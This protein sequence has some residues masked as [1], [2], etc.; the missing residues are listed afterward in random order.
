MNPSCRQTSITS[1]IALSLCLVIIANLIA[2]VF[3]SPFRAKAAPFTQAMIRLDRMAAGE[4]DDI[5]VVVKPAT[6]AT[7]NDF[8]I[9]FH[10]DFSVDSTNTNITVSTTGLPAEVA[11][12]SLTAWPGIGS[13]A[14][15]VSGELVTFSSDD[16]TPGTLYGFFITGGITN[17]ATPGQ[18][19][20]TMRTRD[21]GPTEIDSTDVALRIISDDQIVITAIVP[22]TF[23]FVLSANADSFVDDL[24]PTAI[25]ATSGVTVTLSTNAY[26]GWVTW[27]RSQN[28]SLDSA[29][30]GESI[31]TQGTIDG[32][33]TT[34]TAG[35]NFYQLAVEATTDSGVGT[36]TVTIAPEY[37]CF[38]TASQGGT[39]SAIYEEIATSDG[40]TDGDVITLEARAAISAVTG[41]ASDYTDTW[42]VVG[43][44]YF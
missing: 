39:F 8:Q 22:P 42:T 20:T 31:D 26:N 33:C 12:E 28:T 1:R 13:N 41:A 16:L 40:T 34:I 9:D 17:P 18:Y 14:S 38:G 4:S 3:F 24:D 11:G 19:R 23:G 29:T 10:E 44:A 43:A 15:A 25:I 35:S 37:D 5:L 27:L 30:T 21:S 32:S 36:G 2:P 6:T 7:E